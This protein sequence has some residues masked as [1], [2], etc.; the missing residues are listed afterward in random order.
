M[1]LLSE[2]IIFEIYV[3]SKY[4]KDPPGLTVYID[5]LQKFQGLI[6]EQSTVIKFTHELIFGSH[7]LQMDRVGK[8]NQQMCK[9]ENGDT[10]GQDLI[11]DY[12][13]I[14]GV[15]IRNIIWTKSYYEPEYPEPWASQQRSLGI[16]LEQ[17]VLGE[18]YF[19]H[20]GR[21][22]L[23]FTSPFYRFIMDWME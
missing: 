23:E 15:D 14:D 7:T 1:S 6:T 19:G 21:W 9:K 8:T 20:N 3:I 17:R 12:I 22:S 13:K 2:K 4:W 16:K 5:N 10:E 11:I 18:T